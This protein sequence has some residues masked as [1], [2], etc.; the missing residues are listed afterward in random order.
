MW[1][2]L[3][4]SA[5][6]AVFYA[7]E[8]A[9]KWD[10]N[11]VGPEHLLLGLLRE[12][13]NIG[14]RI[15]NQLG[16]GLEEVRQGVEAH[17][18]RG[19]GGMGRDLE[20]TAAAKQVIDN[21]YEEA[22][23]LNVDYVGPEHLLLGMLGEDVGIASQILTE[24]SVTAE[25]V[26]DQWQQIHDAGKTAPHENPA[27]EDLLNIDEAVKF[28]GTS[29]PTLYRLLGQDEVKGLKVGRQWRFRKADLTAYMERS[30]VAFAA[31]PKQDLERELT[32]FAGEIGQKEPEFSG[33]A[34][35]KTIRLAHQ[36]IRLAIETKAS[37]IHLD[38]TAKDV[39]LRFRV[40]GVLHETRRL[41]A[42]VREAL[43]AQLKMMADMD[44]SEKQLPQAGR[45]PVRHEE[46]DLDLQVASIPSIWGEALTLRIQLRGVMLARLDT[47]DI[48]PGDL[49]NIRDLLHQ[50]NGVFLATGP[51]GSGKMTLLYSCLLEIGDLQ[52]K[53]LTVE[54]P[55]EH[56]L[57]H[58]TQ[59][60]VNK[61]T[62]LT[63]AVALRAF[64]RQDPDV[65][66]VGEM[67]DLEVAKLV[68]EASLAGHLVFSS[69]QTS[70]APSA[71]LRLLDMG[72]EPHL[73][74][75]TVG[76]VVA[77]RL[78]RRLCG[79]CKEP[80]DVSEETTL[81]YVAQLAAEGG[82]AIPVGAVFQRGRGCEQCRDRGYMG[83]I[84]L[85]EVLTMGETLVQAVLRRASVEEM[86]EIAVANGMQTL[87]ADGIRKAVE[88]QTT[89][90]EVLRVVM[91]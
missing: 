64:L 17:L 59:V 62:G 85:Y 18:Q 42:G 68:V 83:R 36:I 51:A 31:A 40:D 47:L 6:K 41:P 3:N 74:T 30:P 73:V 1:Q 14:A 9:G 58:T 89:I 33:D 91:V 34:E 77:M 61:K 37:D 49:K 72:V 57:P 63:F 43:T 53:M 12:G 79:H 56:A 48:M 46:K 26:N 13:D 5:R 55:V 50:P 15:L 11:F 67:R 87:L 35:A 16:V 44:V 70:D 65:I 23:R 39:L 32:F 24:L 82:Y 21:A 45:I 54:D 25:A 71:L 20:L 29:K 81:S 60:R 10:E 22:K 19:T 84:A 75:S 69:L 90:D 76:G 78:C 88:G 2:K 4:E 66:L 80:V 28:L 38:P 8:E 7:Q 52:K 86:T 27:L